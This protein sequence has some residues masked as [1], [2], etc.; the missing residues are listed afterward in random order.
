MRYK[1]KDVFGSTEDFNAALGRRSTA[2]K[3]T[4][5][6]ASAAAAGAI[7][8]LAIEKAEFDR[9]AKVRD[10]LAALDTETFFGQIKFG[11]TGQ[12]NSLEPPV[13][14]I[15]GGKPVVIYADRHQ[16]GRL[17]VHQ[18]VAAAGGSAAGGRFRQRAMLRGS[19]TAA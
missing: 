3:P 8:Q 9:S 15:Q 14:Q 12:I 1:G 2:A 11:P 6:E 13:F 5:S 18:R 17:Q 4:T 10:A 16:A 19:D 7:L